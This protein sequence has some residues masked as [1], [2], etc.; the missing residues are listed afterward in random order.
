MTEESLFNEALALSSPERA[1][2][3]DAACA[4]QPQ[5]QAAVEALLAAQE[6]SG[7][8]LGEPPTAL[9]RTVESEPGQARRL[10]TEE[11][12]ADPAAAFA[13]AC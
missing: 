12:I 11:H 13:R 10:V 2:F 6:R 1:A 4:G 3:L 9:G 5:L 7:N 8:L